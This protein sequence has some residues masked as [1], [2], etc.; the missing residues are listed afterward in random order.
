MV[1]IG[2]VSWLVSERDTLRQLNATDF[3]N[4]LTKSQIEDMA[5]VDELEVVKEFQVCAD[6]G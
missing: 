5:G 1:A 4:V 6:T 2:C 3:S